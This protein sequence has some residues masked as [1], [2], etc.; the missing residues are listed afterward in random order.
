METNRYSDIYNRCTNGLT[1][2]EVEEDYKLSIFTNSEKRIRYRKLQKLPVLNLVAFHSQEIL[3]TKIIMP[4]GKGK[5]IPIISSYDYFTIK[6]GKR[7]KVCSRLD[8]TKCFDGLPS[9]KLYVALIQ[10]L[11]SIIWIKLTTL[12][13]LLKNSTITGSSS[14][15]STNSTKAAKI[16]NISNS[17]MNNVPFEY[18]DLKLF[19]DFEE[20]GNYMS[21]DIKDINTNKKHLN[22]D[23]TFPSR[24]FEMVM[25]IKKVKIENDDFNLY[26]DNLNSLLAE[27]SNEVKLQNKSEL[28]EGTKVLYSLEELNKDLKEDITKLN[29]EKIYQHEDQ[30]TREINSNEYYHY[31]HKNDLITD[32]CFSN[33]SNSPNWKTNTDENKI[34]KKNRVTNINTLIP[35]NYEEAMNPEKADK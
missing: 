27:Y 20:L 5:F 16:T 33:P 31:C 12:A 2:D 22:Y 24:R 8:N 18:S 19:F 10:T 26:L 6:R 3:A 32:N 29:I 34:L 14:K 11:K 17:I 7:V 25:K 23:N 13:A 21:K 35:K 1:L 15:T 30:I 9:A 4:S 28:S